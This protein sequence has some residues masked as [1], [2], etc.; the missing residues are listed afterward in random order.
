MNAWPHDRD[1]SQ[2]AVC[3][4]LM[5]SM[6]SVDHMVERSFTGADS[7]TLDC[8]MLRGMLCLKRVACQSHYAASH[9]YNCGCMIHSTG[10]LQS[11][12]A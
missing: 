8:D 2:V 10:H 1:I 5:C 12:P 11:T 9:S 4:I 7:I 3:A 6:S